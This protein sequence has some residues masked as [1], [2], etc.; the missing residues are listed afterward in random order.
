MLFRLRCC[1]C[2]VVVCIVVVCVVVFCWCCDVLIDF[3]IL[4]CLKLVPWSVLLL[5]MLLF[6][7]F[8]FC[9]ACYLYCMICS[10]FSLAT[11]PAN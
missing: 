2:I 11:F 1:V 8:L 4:L 10:L 5:Y 3:I 7:L 9:L 6:E